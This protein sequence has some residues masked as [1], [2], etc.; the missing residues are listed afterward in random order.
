MTI[1]E[2]Y[3]SN[4]PS[5]DLGID[6]DPKASFIGLLDALSNGICVY[7]YIDCGDSIIRERIF[8]ELSNQLGKD[9][10]YVY[11]LWSTTRKKKYDLWIGGTLALENITLKE[12][13][14]DKQEWTDKGYKDAVITD[15]LGKIIH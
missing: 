13:L 12:A 8:A 15:E 7:D 1:K 14:Q 10:D 4:Y 2:F 9:Y 11:N 3:L 5:D 6:I